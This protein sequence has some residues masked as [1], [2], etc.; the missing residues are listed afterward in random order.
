MYVSERKEG[1][2]NRFRERERVKYIWRVKRTH[3]KVTSLAPVLALCPRPGTLVNDEFFIAESSG[4]SILLRSS[5]PDLM[6]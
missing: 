1:E 2:T 4:L 3:G 6:K 5:T